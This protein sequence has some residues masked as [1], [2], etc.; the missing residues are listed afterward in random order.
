MV[1]YQYQ[2]Q[3]MA[4]L[5]GGRWLLTALKGGHVVVAD[6]DHPDTPQHNLISP[7]E[8][9]DRWTILGM[10]HSVY[11]YERPLSF[12][13]ALL[14]GPREDEVAEF[15]CRQM[16]VWRVTLSEDG[17]LLS[18]LPINSF[19]TNGTYE[20]LA[21]REE[22]I[23]GDLYAR[24]AS[25]LSPKE[26]LVEVFDW[27]RSSCDLHQKTI[28]R[29]PFPSPTDFGIEILWEKRIL[30][31]N[32]KCLWIYDIPD[33]Q[34]DTQCSQRLPEIVPPAQVPIHVLTLP[35]GGFRFS[36]LSPIKT[37]GPQAQ[38]ALCTG[39]GVY[40]LNIDDDNDCSP[41]FTTLVRFGSRLKQKG[42]ACVGLRKTLIYHG[43]Y[44]AS[45]ISYSF[46]GTSS[47]IA[48][49]VVKR[50]KLTEARNMFARVIMDEATARVVQQQLGRSLSVMYFGSYYRATE[51]PDG[52]R[53]A[54]T[55]M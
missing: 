36:G 26:T 12:T 5:P 6:L 49:P 27:R 42:D 44:S 19:W 33:L 30:V 7:Q 8:E 1:I 32:D 45:A 9:S 28:L 38:L 16:R 15:P 54:L 3:A 23:S 48:R 24:A 31:L 41:S 29:L 25:Y 34:P 18:A 35:G 13:L 46:I 52:Q 21:L 17:T 4:L 47:G 39:S 10:L 50:R 22:V 37:N 53:S 2:I 55:H 20:T 40:G 43:N 11:Q 51:T 14:H